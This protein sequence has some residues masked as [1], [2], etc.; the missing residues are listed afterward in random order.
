MVLITKR[1]RYFGGIGLMEVLWKMEK[2]ILDL[3]IGLDIT[4]HDV[5]HRFWYSCWMGTTSFK[6]KL[7]QYL[8]SI[9]EEVLYEIFLDLHKSYDALDKGRCLEILEGYEVGTQAIRLLHKY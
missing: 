7:I 4:R 5:L 2:V 8:T 1:G 9:M 3:H 6:A